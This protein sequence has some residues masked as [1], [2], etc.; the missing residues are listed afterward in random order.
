MNDS[1]NE[2]GNATSPADDG[3]GPNGNGL[4]PPEAAS[5]AEAAQLPVRSQLAL[6]DSYLAG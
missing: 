2:G 4:Q 6:H 1:F 5:S 3:L